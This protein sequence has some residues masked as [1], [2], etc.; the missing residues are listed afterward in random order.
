MFGAIVEAA[1]GIIRTSGYPYLNPDM[2]DPIVKEG[3][4]RYAVETV[5]HFESLGWLFKDR[6]L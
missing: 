5:M 2:I 6:E 1:S 4:L 3:R